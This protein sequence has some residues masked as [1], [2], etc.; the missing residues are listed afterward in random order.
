MA[1]QIRNLIAKWNATW[2]SPLVVSRQHDNGQFRINLVDYPEPEN[3]EDQNEEILETINYY[4]V[5]WMKQTEDGEMEKLASIH[6]IR[7]WYRTS[8]SS[9]MR[10][11][12]LQDISHIRRNSKA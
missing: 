9:F 4:L 11:P 8:N 5:V 1:E 2:P 3:Y 6:L 12:V 10:L 7:S